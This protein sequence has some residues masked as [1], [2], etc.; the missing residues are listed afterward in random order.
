MAYKPIRTWN[1]PQADSLE[2]VLSTVEAVS[3]GLTSFQRIAAHIGLS[4]RQGRYY[5]R[6]AEILNLIELAG[7]NVSV[8]TPIGREYITETQ[9]VKRHIVKKQLLQVDIFQTIYIK[10]R[11]RSNFCKQVDIL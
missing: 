3:N 9:I 4:E 8:L 7:T 5:R 1:I 10:I 2:Q 6:A 11:A